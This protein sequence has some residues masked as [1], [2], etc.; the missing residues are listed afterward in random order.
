MRKVRTK[1]VAALCLYAGTAVICPLLAKASAN[2][3]FKLEVQ[4]VKSV[5]YTFK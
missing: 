5:N 3:M 1:L 4:F 2:P